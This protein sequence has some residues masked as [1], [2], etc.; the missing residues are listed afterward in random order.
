MPQALVWC[1]CKRIDCGNM[2]QTPVD[3][4]CKA[5]R[6]GEQHAE[7]FP[8]TLLRFDSENTGNRVCVVSHDVATFQAESRDLDSVSD[9]GMKIH[10][11]NQPK[12]QGGAEHRTKAYSD[13]TEST[14]AHTHC[15]EYI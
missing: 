4:E 14:Q 6:A 5:D 12:S 13:T 2:R 7:S 3:S 10:S 9:H 11:H 8:S 15:E 1:V